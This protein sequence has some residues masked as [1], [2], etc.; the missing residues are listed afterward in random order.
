MERPFQSGEFSMFG[1]SLKSRALVSAVIVGMIGVSGLRAKEEKPIEVPTC[2]AKIG[3]LSVLEPEDKWWLAY[4]LESPEA[5]IKVFVSQSKCFTLLDRGKGLAAAQQERAL[6]SSGEMRGGSNI[7]KGQMK[8][9]DY[10]LVPDLVNKN[11]KAGGKN[12]GG[13]LGGLVG[14]GAGVV[15]GGISLKSKTADVVLTLTDVRSTEQV[16]LTQGHAKKTDLGWGG[17]GAAFF[18]GF[19]AGGASSYA[20][21]E[22]GQVVTMA[23]LDSYVKLVQEIKSIKPDAKADNVSQSVSMA[24]PGRMYAKA[25]LKAT[26]VRDLD[27]GMMLYPTGEK[28]GIWWKV[29]DELGNEGWVPSTLFNLAK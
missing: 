13:I 21:T 18:G 11:A 20:N 25:D 8:A 9:A 24:K 23:Y 27:P 22:I 1:A 3:T 28:E 4:E 16:A 2:D 7:G 10:V 26:V 14:H 5:L 6:A 29:T 12:I 17:G 15:A 19:A